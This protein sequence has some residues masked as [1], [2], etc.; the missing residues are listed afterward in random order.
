MSN[1][2]HYYLRQCLSPPRLGW[3]RRN[4]L[5]VLL[6]DIDSTI[7][8]LA[9]HKIAKFH[10]ARG[11]SVHWNL[12]MLRHAVDK[13]Y[14]SCIFTKNKAEADE[15]A[16]YGANVGGT[17]YDLR[18]K[19]PDEIENFPC[20]INWGF[21]T[22][23]CIRRCPFCFVP[24]KEGMIHTVGDLYDV[25]DGQ[26]KDVVL[27]DNNILALPDHFFKIAGQLRKEKV[28]VN[29]NQGLDHRLLTSRIC[30]E[31]KTIRHREYY[32]AFDS[33]KDMDRV[34][35]AIELLNDA[36]LKRNTWLTLVGFDSTIEEDIARLDYLK[37]RNQN[38]YVMR[39][40]G[41]RDSKMLNHLSRWANNHSWFQGVTFKQFLERN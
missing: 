7:P 22:R 32:F 14:A 15:W 26:S 1:D 36:G 27:M 41:R 18:I 19:L 31:L 25:W 23:G 17:G 4:S 5:D 35:K 24:E 6:I 13:I 8:N 38:A 12:P 33:I 30:E 28:R 34:G 3:G 10:E 37:E 16:E 9:L 2:Q 29:F 21:T 11:D 20:R 40:N 39:Y